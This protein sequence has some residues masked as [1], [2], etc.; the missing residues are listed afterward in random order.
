MQ[1]PN[2]EKEKREEG[3]EGDKGEV[4]HDRKESINEK[5][6]DDST[7]DVCDGAGEEESK[8]ES[9]IVARQKKTNDEKNSLYNLTL[10]LVRRDILL[11]DIIDRLEAE[12]HGILR[13]LFS[14]WLMQ[15]YIWRMMN[16]SAH[17]NWIYEHDDWDSED[18]KED[19]IRICNDQTGNPSTESM[20]GVESEKTNSAEQIEEADIVEGVEEEKKDEK[21][22]DESD[23]HLEEKSKKHDETGENKSDEDHAEDRKTAVDD[24][25][26]RDDGAK[27]KTAVSEDEESQSPAS[28]ASLPV[29]A[30]PPP[31]PP[32]EARTIYLKVRN[33]SGE[34]LTE[35]AVRE[36]LETF[37]LETC[38][39]GGKQAMVV[40]ADL[41]DVEWLLWTSMLSMRSSEE[42][43]AHSFLLLDAFPK[44]RIKFAM[45]PDAPNSFRSL[46]E[47]KCRAKNQNELDKAAFKELVQQILSNWSKPQPSNKDLTAAF[48]IADAD[49]SGLVSEEE[50]AGLLALIRRGEVAGLGKSSIFASGASTRKRKSE[51]QQ[52]LAASMPGSAKDGAEAATNATSSSRPGDSEEVS[53]GTDEVAPLGAGA[54][55]E[56]NIASDG[57]VV[58]MPKKAEEGPSHA[59]P[60]DKDGH[61]KDNHGESEA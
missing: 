60:S 13:S 58:G 25:E 49:Q 29:A 27:L 16:L 28:P 31:P 20:L 1:Q 34:A 50:L 52:K 36:A 14:K 8:E 51:F 56:T 35:A 39:L 11:L 42:L 30:P 38:V 10:R 18:E 54:D 57:K 19:D 45:I 44:H 5:K 24:H 41:K 6:S 23:L 32:V 46:F 2:E 22:S 47:E 33:G 37:T 21:V 48:D 9:G 4:S 26:H 40:F 53:S 12:G 15:F 43:K 17:S 55:A 61:V 59:S 3:E 7:G